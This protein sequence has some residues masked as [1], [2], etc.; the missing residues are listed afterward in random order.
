MLKF[1]LNRIRNILKKEYLEV[2]N[3]LTDN[4][5]LTQIP[6]IKKIGWRIMAVNNME[7][8]KILLNISKSDLNASKLL[9]V[10]GHYS[11]A[12]FFLQ[13][14][15]EKATKCYGLMTGIITEDSLKSKIGHSPAKIYGIMANKQREK[16][17]AIKKIK[18]DPILKENMIIQKFE[19]KKSENN[20]KILLKFI[21]NGKMSS[22][23][24]KNLMDLIKDL[25]ELLDYTQNFSVDE[26]FKEFKKQFKWI[27]VTDDTPDNKKITTEE[28]L[29]DRFI[30]TKK[31]LVDVP[32]ISVSLLY[33]SVITQKHTNISRY[34]ENG[35]NPLQIYNESH[36]LI[37]SFM[38]IIKIMEVV[39][40]KMSELISSKHDF[41]TS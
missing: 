22:I 17:D 29:K 16:I 2:W 18:K 19:I 10:N 36:P 37:E 24:K 41:I 14:S 5:F 4:L 27:E 7:L 39:L 3:H 23:S 31:D 9:Y 30:E 26:H 20:L 8:G 11:Q 32:F 35:K 6:I 28:Q 33:I 15:A 12:I 21:V 38:Q 40:E 34:P 25:N 13:Q 1:D